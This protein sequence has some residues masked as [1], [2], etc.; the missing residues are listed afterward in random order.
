MKRALTAASV[1]GGAILMLAAATPASAL[2]L[3]KSHTGT[4]EGIV[5]QTAPGH[6][7]GGGGGVGRGMGGGGRGMMGGGHS[8]G[9]R[10]MMRGGSGPGRGMVGRGHGGGPRM[11]SGP[12]GPRHAGP[13]RHHHHPRH[14]R[15]PYRGFY[16]GGGVPYYY[17]YGGYDDCGWLR[18]RAL[19]TG[20]PYWWSRYYAC[21][22]D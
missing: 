13:G 22:E 2:P 9:G 19:A 8:G 7:G 21:I 3:T 17:G 12:R 16:Y 1:V 18:R 5:H 4:A 20:S 10:G 6:R 15:G 14:H 11:H